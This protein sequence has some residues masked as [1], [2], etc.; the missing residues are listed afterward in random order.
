MNGR[1]TAW[2][3]VGGGVSPARVLGFS[4]TTSIGCAS[5]TVL[6]SSPKAL[7]GITGFDGKGG[8]VDTFF[9]RG[10]APVPPDAVPATGAATPPDRAQAGSDDGAPL[11]GGIAAATSGT[12]HALLT[13]SSG[14]IGD[15][16]AP[17]DEDGVRG[18]GGGEVGVL[19]RNGGGVDGVFARS[20]GVAAGVCDRS[21]GVGGVF[22]RA[23]SLARRAGPCGSC[24]S[25]RA[26][27]RRSA[28]G[29]GE[30]ASINDW[31]SPCGSSVVS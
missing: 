7:G 10:A 1:S 23:W 2:I 3:L 16:T 15:D 25:G 28:A 18:R 27:S 4:E 29:P 31:R 21:G 12:D 6:K 20:G 13:D 9:G 30:I 26:A 11:E 24:A 8:G 14:F 19:P 17:V 5:A 22:G